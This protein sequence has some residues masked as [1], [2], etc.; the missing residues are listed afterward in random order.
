MG[1]HKRGNGHPNKIINTPL[2]DRMCTYVCMPS[3]SFRKFL[4]QYTVR[5]KLPLLKHLHKWEEGK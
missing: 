4:M 5:E 2:V 1:K 3:F